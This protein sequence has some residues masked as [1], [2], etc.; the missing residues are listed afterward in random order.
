MIS[1]YV[2]ELDL[3]CDDILEANSN[4]QSV[5]AINKLGRPVKR[6]SRPGYSKQFPDKTG[7]VLFMQC[8]LEISMGKDFDEQYG[9]INYH[10]SE[11]GNVTMLTFPIDDH[12]ILV[13]ASKNVS[14]I[15]LAKKIANIIH[16]YKHSYA[17][18]NMKD[19]SIPLPV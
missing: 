18:S 17:S 4:I 8:V 13:T 6:S 3:L 16:G 7:E 12:V 9:P 11:R 2:T 5:A 10:M 15:S 19:S 14:P 1:Q